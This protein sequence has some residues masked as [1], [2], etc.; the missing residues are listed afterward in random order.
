MPVFPLRKQRYR[1][2]LRK[3]AELKGRTFVSL[4]FTMSY[5][6]IYVSEPLMQNNFLFKQYMF[7]VHS[8]SVF[9]DI[10]QCP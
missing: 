5:V 4:N 2:S 10:S 6:T 1:N 3:V 8:T 7:E 9:S